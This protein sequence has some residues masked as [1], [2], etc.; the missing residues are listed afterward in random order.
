M[1]H[2]DCLNSKKKERSQH[3]MRD[4]LIE[5]TSFPHIST[6]FTIVHKFQANKKKILRK[7]FKGIELKTDQF[8]LTNE[9]KPQKRNHI[10]HRWCDQFK[11]NV[12]STKQMKKKNKL[13]IFLFQWIGF[14][15]TEHTDFR[16]SWT[17]NKMVLQ[18]FPWKM[19]VISSKHLPVFFGF[20]GSVF[21]QHV[22]TQKYH[23]SWSRL[24]TLVLD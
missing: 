15:I 22:F 5:K 3:E 21:V 8:R 12:H 16:E 14:R 19:W 24:M 1:W 20:C 11:Q 13:N 23:F 18:I 10:R 7:K 2:W 6:I 17:S 9:T 4:N